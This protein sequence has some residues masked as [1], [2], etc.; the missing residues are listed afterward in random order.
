MADKADNC[1]NCGH[2]T[3]DGLAKL[4][5][6]AKEH[7]IYGTDFSKPLAELVELIRNQLT[8]ARGQIHDIIHAY[9]GFKDRFDSAEGLLTCGISYLYHVKQE[10]EQHTIRH[11]D[12]VKFNPRG[13][14]SDYTPGCFCCG[15]DKDLYSNI[16]GFVSSKADGEKVVGMFSTGVYLDF[17][18]YEPNW[19]QVKIGA[20]KDHL[21]NLEHLYRLMVGEHVI[22]PKK[23]ASAQSFAFRLCDPSTETTV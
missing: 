14:G 4:A 18:D 19:I 16:S 20:C 12:G 2:W 22:T 23:I 9:P 1:P 7:P 10:M 6:Q 8:N 11:E 17:R 5:A 3:Y 15:G 21:P 13:I